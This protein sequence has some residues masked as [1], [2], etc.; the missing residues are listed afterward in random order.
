MKLRKILFACIIGGFLIMFMLLKYNPRNNR[1]YLENRIGTEVSRVYPTQN[2][3]DLFEQFPNGFIVYQARM[4]NEKIVELKLTGTEKGAPIKGELIEAERKSGE[5]TRV[6][7]VEYYNGK[8]TF[9]DEKSANELWPQQSFLFQKITLNKSLLSTLKLKDKYYSSMNGSFE[10]NYD[11][12]LPEINEYLS[13]PASKS[14]ELSFG[15]SNSNRNYYYS[16]VIEDKDGYYFRE[17]VYE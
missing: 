7:S 12:N 15:G 3:E 1:A 16:V 2:L 13:F 8:Y 4:M 5:N 11:V 9:S 14:V 17:T 10:L 6:V